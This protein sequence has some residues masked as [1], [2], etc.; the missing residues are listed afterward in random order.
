MNHHLWWSGPSRLSLES[1]QWPSTPSHIS[2]ISSCEERPGLCHFSTLDKP[3]QLWNL[4]SRY[5]S[6]YRLL[7]I[8]TICQRVIAK[9]KHT[10][11]SSIIDTISPKEIENVLFF[12]I[13][14]TQHAHFKDTINSLLTNQPLSNSNSLLRFT[15]FV[16]NNGILRIGGRLKP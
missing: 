11:H 14:M 4:I 5:S 12:W 8:T 7:R 3:L 9:F 15:P 2:E 13:Q 16:D 6:L 1:S 10:L